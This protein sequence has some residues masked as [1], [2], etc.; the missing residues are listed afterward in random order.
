MASRWI[1]PW[2]SIVFIAVAVSREAGGQEGDEPT[3]E[4][5]YARAARRVFLKLRE[6]TRDRLVVEHIKT[7]AG[8]FLGEKPREEHAGSVEAA[9]ELGMLLAEEGAQ[10]LRKALDAVGRYKLKAMDFRRCASEALL[11][12][13]LA[14]RRGEEE[15]IVWALGRALALPGGDDEASEI[16]GYIHSRAGDD[17][18]RVLGVVVRALRDNA[19]RYDAERLIDLI[20]GVYYGAIKK[21]RLE[22]V[23]RRFL[24]LL[25]DKSE[26]VRRFGVDFIGDYVDMASLPSEDVKKNRSWFNWSLELVNADAER[27]SAVEKAL[28]EIRGTWD[29]ITKKLR[30]AIGLALEAKQQRIAHENRLLNEVRARLKDESLSPEERASLQKQEAAH[31][32][33]AAHHRAM[34]DRLQAAIR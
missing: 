28:P 11:Q 32:A 16:R 22:E 20:Q 26:A 25:I 7:I 21:G 30:A 29:E 1:L 5:T 24:A 27:R 19:I 34:A 23:F 17:G 8:D 4:I 31:V 9:R 18:P 12:I 10:T 33:D 6:T 3:A 2:A 15:R 13:G 14:G